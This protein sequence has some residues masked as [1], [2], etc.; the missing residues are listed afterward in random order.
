MRRHV[1]DVKAFDGVSFIME[2][3]K[4]L[5]LVGE[6]GCAKFT[7]GR[8]I[9][10]AYPA[11]DGQIL[12]RPENDQSID[13]SK[14]RGPALRRYLLHARINFQDPYSSLNP[15]RTVMQIIE[16]PLVCLTSMGAAERKER[17]LSLLEDVGLVLAPRREV[18][19]CI[20]WRAAP[21]NRHRARA[22]GQTQFADLR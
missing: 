12:Y 10:G 6:S 13:V 9:A 20:Q 2:P 7:L 5:G 4:T 16:E 17:V 21:T 3:G 11:T 8:T 15:R 14:L 18:S 1:S 22:H 19:P